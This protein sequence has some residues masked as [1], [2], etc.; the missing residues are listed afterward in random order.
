MDLFGHAHS[1]N[2]LFALAPRVQPFK[3]Q[4]TLR[5]CYLEYS[6][7]SA[8]VV[9]L[10]SG[11][12]GA[13]LDHPRVPEGIAADQSLA[14]L[15]KAEGANGVTTSNTKCITLHLLLTGIDGMHY[16]M[17]LLLWWG[18]GGSTM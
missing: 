14:A 10:C 2:L 7:L 1:D 9:G 8:G 17:K 4:R 13:A 5:L 18:G 12:G 6:V 11:T 15:C 3:R 16:P